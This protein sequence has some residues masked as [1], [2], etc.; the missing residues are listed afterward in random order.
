MEENSTEGPKKSGEADG[1]RLTMNLDDE[2]IK[3]ARKLSS[4]SLSEITIQVREHKREYDNDKSK[5]MGHKAIFL[6]MQYWALL[7]RLR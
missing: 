7:A 1:C 6:L 2:F 3:H 5:H 4:M